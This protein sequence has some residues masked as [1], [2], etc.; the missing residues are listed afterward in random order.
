MCSEIINA[1]QEKQ[2]SNIYELLSAEKTPTYLKREG[3]L[4]EVRT[5]IYQRNFSIFTIMVSPGNFCE[6]GQTD[7]HAWQHVKRQTKTFFTDS[8]SLFAR[9]RQYFNNKISS[10]N[11][12]ANKQ[13]WLW[14]IYYHCKHSQVLLQ[15]LHVS[16]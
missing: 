1:I 9:L 4:L 3:K 16:G 11:S 7:L 12:A 15:L 6:T 10:T 2:F 5:P 8:V 14:F 13:H